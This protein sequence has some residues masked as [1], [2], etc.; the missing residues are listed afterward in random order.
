[1]LNFL[2]AQAKKNVEK[3]YYAR[4]GILFLGIICLLTI[5][6]ISF[7]IPAYSSSVYEKNMLTME[8]QQ[9][10]L[11]ASNCTG[12]EAECIDPTVQIKSANLLLDVLKG[13]AGTPVSLTLLEILNN[14]NSGIKITAI[15][16]LGETAD[17]YKF[18]VSGQSAT[19]EELLAFFENLKKG[20]RFSGVDLPT[21][22]FIK[23]TDI[24]FNLTIKVKN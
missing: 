24:D 9:I 15:K 1:M 7:M 17:Q 2:P 3:E 23:R 6:S 11:G 21:S 16:Y 13:E 20:T 22:G 12:G 19:R 14:K 18:S 10:D 4:V 8:V 5:Y